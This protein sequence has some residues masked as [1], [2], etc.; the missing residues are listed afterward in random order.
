MSA[1]TRSQKDNK[2]MN[3][4]PQ[5]HTEGRQGSNGPIK[6]KALKMEELNLIPDENTI[7]PFKHLCLHIYRLFLA[8]TGKCTC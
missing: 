4:L 2:I 5:E 3:Y 7:L 8:G 1:N 6:L